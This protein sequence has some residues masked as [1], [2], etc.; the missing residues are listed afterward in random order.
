MGY[1]YMILIFI[2]ILGGFGFW[3]LLKHYNYE[4]NFKESLIY[5]FSILILTIICLVDFDLMQI[6]I[7]CEILI[8]IVIYF[9][10]LL[11]IYYIMR[12]IKL[13]KYVPMK[14]VIGYILISIINLVILLSLLSKSPSYID[15]WS[16][17]ALYLIHI[18]LSIIFIASLLSINIIVFIIKSIKKDNINYKNIDYKVSKFSFLNISITM[19][20]IG[21]I[22]GINNYNKYNYN[23][24]I[25]K[26]KEIVINYLNKEYSNYEFE[27]I[28]TYETK[29]N[30]WM[31]GC[32]TS[33]FRNEIETKELNKNFIIDVKKEG[34]TIY[35][36][37]FKKI[38]EE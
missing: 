6:Y 32:R 22:F 2:G 34:L 8:I 31:F 1:V 17:L 12:S 21:L 13:K 27:I 3:K 5:P 33:V 24:L 18:A 26:Q 37:E 35:E 23:K 36:D 9:L 4:L 11:S 20:L 15:G 16:T 28:K 7:K 14:T 10:A 29:V 25:E 30:C 19:L 38:I